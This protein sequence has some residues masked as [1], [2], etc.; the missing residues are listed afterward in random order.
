MTKRFLSIFL[1]FIMLFII[2]ACG[3]KAEVKQPENDT[4]PKENVEVPAPDEEPADTPEEKDDTSPAPADDTQSAPAFTSELVEYKNSVK[5]DNGDEIY[6][7][8]I[9]YPKVTVAGNDYVSNSINSY[10]EATSNEIIEEEKTFTEEAQD[11]YDYSLENEDYA[12]SPY[13]FEQSPAV[14]LLKGNVYSVFF[15][16]FADFGGA[17]PSSYS[18]GVNFDITTGEKLA[19]REL[20]TDGSA[21]TYYLRD[22]IINEIKTDSLRDSELTTEDFFQDYED[23]LVQ[24]FETEPNW[25]VE[26]R[27]ICIIFNTY[28][29][30]PY[31]YG[32]IFVVFPWDEIKD[33]IDPEKIPGL[34]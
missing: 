6:N 5:S 25:Y 23:T 9:A 26:D 31:A 19:L 11:A 22:T 33:Y 34:I 1:I 14:E 32:P 7:F 3:K 28:E 30:A 4:D 12:F 18:E 2:T 8:Y 27:G 20:A 16:C 13:T 10:L 21:F 15:T 24:T 17:H 29:L